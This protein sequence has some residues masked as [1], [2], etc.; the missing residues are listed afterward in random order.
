M[1]TSITQNDYDATE[2]NTSIVAFFKRFHIG[3]IL[4]AS[5]IY[6]TKGVSPL[7]IMEYLF[8]LVF[9]GK[10]MYMDHL[11][12]S[13]DNSCAEDCPIYFRPQTI[14]TTPVK[15]CMMVIWCHFLLS[16]QDSLQFSNCEV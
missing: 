6:K 9:T 4:R 3:S 12:N 7:K 11:L 15:G 13:S 16:F 14:N 10:S 1:S 8:T 5:N 2:I